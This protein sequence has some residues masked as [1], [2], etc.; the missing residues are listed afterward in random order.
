[1]LGVRERVVLG[2]WLGVLNGAC[3]GDDGTLNSPPAS[4]LRACANIKKHY[5]A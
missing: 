3:V 1:M 5:I 2:V 4:L